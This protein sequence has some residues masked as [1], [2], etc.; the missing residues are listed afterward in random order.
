MESLDINDV[1]REAILLVQREVF[2]HGASLD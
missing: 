1:I 2:N